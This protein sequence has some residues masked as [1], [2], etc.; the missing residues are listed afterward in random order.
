MANI[1]ELIKDIRKAIFGKDVRESIASAIEKCYEEATK[2][3]NANM[4]VSEARGIFKTLNERL[5]N[6]DTAKANKA[7]IKEAI[8]EETS[9][10]NRADNNLQTQ[11]D[12]LASGSPFVADSIAEMTDIN[13][14]YVNSSD[15]HWYYYN[16]STWTNGGIY[17]ASENSD[18][19]NALLKRDISIY[20]YEHAT[21]LNANNSGDTISN[22]ASNR[23][24]FIPVSP[25]ET[26][27]VGRNITDSKY[28]IVGFSDGAQVG[29]NVF[30]KVTVNINGQKRLYNNPVKITAPENATHICIWFYNNN[31]NYTVNEL[32]KS[33]FVYKSDYLSKLIEA[34]LGVFKTNT[35]RINQNTYLGE[36]S[37][38]NNADKSKAYV[39]YYGEDNTSVPE[40]CPET[41][42]T[43]AVLLTFASEEFKTTIQIY[44]TNKKIYYR[45]CDDNENW[46]TWIILVDNEYKE[47]NKVFYIG[48]DREFTTLK[49]GIEEAI[50]YRNSIVYVDPGIY[51]IL[52]EYGGNDYID[53]NYSGSIFGNGIILKNG[54]HVIFSTN[55]KV[56]C[57]FEG[58]NSKFMDNFSPFNVGPGGFTL[59]NLNIEC[60]KVRYCIHD[61]LFSSDDTYTETHYI[62]CK[63]YLNNNQNTVRE[64][65]SCIGGGMPI[66]GSVIIDGCIFESTAQNSSSDMT[67][68]VDY[69]QNGNENAQCKILIKN[70]ICLG[71]KDNFSFSNLGSSTKISDVIV[72][73]CK[74]KIAPK[75]S[76]NNIYPEN[77]RMISYNNEI[78]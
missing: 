5:N 8:K 35:V 12:S 69:H 42:I 54:V 73:N 63:M 64:N 28:F 48:P 21:I 72:T 14:I 68:G 67:G 66:N 46:G 17:Q 75:L 31:D 23:T 70:S 38:F 36:L 4:E 1:A 22:S 49:E 13:R 9:A 77:I 2:E 47:S 11:I 43:N 15:G 55:S 61:D 26:Y 37:N 52:E 59:E 62:N 44:I 41:S 65:Y 19:V 20:D 16:G 40:N 3:G 45:A 6:S 50:K 58:S 34:S 57:N 29:A 30:N 25:G 39:F 32:A 51:D 10:R 33:I 60:S 24:L 53:A 74:S 27:L 76:I 78:V 7:D 18:N 56:I 71:N